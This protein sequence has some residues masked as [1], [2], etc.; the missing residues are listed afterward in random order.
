V[1]TRAFERLGIAG[2]AALTVVG[3][4]SGCAAKKKTASASTAAA[5]TAAAAASTGAAAPPSD[6]P[7]QVVATGGG[8]F[9]QQVA[10]S[11]NNKTFQAAA[12]GTGADSMKASVEAFKSIEGSVLKSAPGAIKPDLVTLFG[13][14]DQFYTG[15]AKANY[16]FTKVDPS[17]EAPL[18]TPAVKAAEQNVD[19]YLK[20]TCGLDVGGGSGGTNPSAQAA[21]SAAVASALARLTASPSS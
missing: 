7:S 10:A 2:L 16:D 4:L 13:A 18:E 6:T 21:E 12:T 11:V 14:L 19:A 20:N 17:I 9:C 8:K 5:A 1:S 3:L 15:L